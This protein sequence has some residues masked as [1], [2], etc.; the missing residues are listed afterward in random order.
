MTQNQKLALECVLDWLGNT[1]PPPSL[2][3]LARDEHEDNLHCVTRLL[4][5]CSGLQSAPARQYVAASWA[6]LLDN[7]EKLLEYAFINQNSD[8]EWTLSEVGRIQYL[9]RRGPREAYPSFRTAIGRYPTEEAQVF[10]LGGG[11]AGA[12]RHVEC[13]GVISLHRRGHL[14]TSDPRITSHLGN[15]K[16]RID[17]TL[18]RLQC[19]PGVRPHGG[20][21]NKMSLHPT[22][23]QSIWRNTFPPIYKEMLQDAKELP[24][25]VFHPTITDPTTPRIF[26]SPTLTGIWDLAAR[27]GRQE[28]SEADA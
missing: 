27:E 19:C 28:S 10:H 26:I 18:A 13:Q 11:V 20:V 7:Y 21:L 14:E 5:T 24:P 8:A 22:V 15:E 25:R 9:K 17:S 4:A 23:C 1:P 6:A 12:K 3:I 2:Y 16:I